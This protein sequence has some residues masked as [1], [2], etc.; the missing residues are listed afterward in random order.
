MRVVSVNLAAVGEMFIRQS[1]REHR[2][3]TGIHKQPVTGAVR[4]K[5]LGLAGD[6]QADL[7]V[8]GGL[9]KAVYAYPSEH[10][11]FWAAQRLAVFKR[12]APLPPGSMG[13]N[14]TLEGILEREV[15]VGDRLHVGSAVLQVTEPRRPC[16]KF[17]AKMGF[18]HAVKM[19]VQSG[20]TGFYLRVIEEGEIAAGDT[21]TLAPGARNVSIAQLIEQRLKGRQRD[22]F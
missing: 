16:Y 8:H 21:V 20:F 4:V 18:S 19:M 11:A 10:Y 22:L 3:M 14:L 13:E 7:T 12:E 6:E 5:P 2:I 1:E 17:A 9:D 15:W